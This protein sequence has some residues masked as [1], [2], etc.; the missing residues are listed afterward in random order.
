[1][2]AS[3]TSPTGDLA[4]NPGVCPD[5]ESNWR[6]FV[7]QPTLS[8]LSHTSQGPLTW[9]LSSD[10][11][12][13]HGFGVPMPDLSPSSAAHWLCYLRK[14]PSSFWTP[15]SSF[16]R[17]QQYVF[18]SQSGGGQTDDI[19]GLQGNGQHGRSTQ[20]W[21]NALEL[22]AVDHWSCRDDRAL[23]SSDCS[24]GLAAVSSPLLSKEM[25]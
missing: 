15:L 1:M 17:Q 25:L 8:P 11:T 6:P 4:H 24:T 3:P 12:W 14:S 23:G 2:V 21:K 19:E 10:T 18:F 13:C 22:E 9:V 16:V 20:S 5:W 7:L